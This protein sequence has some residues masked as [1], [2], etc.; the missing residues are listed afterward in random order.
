MRINPNNFPTKST[1]T[2]A[3]EIYSQTGG[4]S[5]RITV[6][7]LMQL[8]QQQVPLNPIIDYTDF[9]TTNN[10]ERSYLGNDVYET[11]LLIN[12]LETFAQG[13]DP[14]PTFNLGIDKLL[15]WSVTYVNSST[16][17]QRLYFSVNGETGALVDNKYLTFA[18][19]SLGTLFIK[20]ISPQ[21]VD[22]D[23]FRLTLKYTQL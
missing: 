18:I 15:E 1:I 21:I 5:R 22:A 12:E 8:V 4:I 23:T 11:V 17:N 2:G 13:L 10:I 3:E 16:G 6:D 7:G 9:P 14:S 19:D 20:E